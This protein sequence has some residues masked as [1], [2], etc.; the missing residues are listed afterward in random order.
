MNRNNAIVDRIALTGKSLGPS[1]IVNTKVPAVQTMGRLYRETVVYKIIEAIEDGRILLVYMP[2]ETRLPANMPYVKAQYHGK[3]VSV[4]D[5]SKFATIEQADGT[6][7]NVQIDPNKLYCLVVPAY[8]DLVLMD[9]TV[10]LPSE[11]IRTMSYLWA[12]MFNKVLTSKKI[13]V[14]NQEKHQAFMYFAMRFFMKYYLQSPDAVVENISL[15]YL[16][17]V[18]T[19][20]VT[21][22]NENLERKQIDLYKDW[23]TFAH[24]MFNNEITNIASFNG[25]GVNM[26]EKLYLQYFDTTFGK[27]GAYLAL[28]TAPYFLYTLFCTFNRGYILNDRAW[29]D[30]VLKEKKVMVNLMTSLYK[31]I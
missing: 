29:E 28:W 12:K 22:I 30:I 6:I 8:I 11:S 10:A 14:N 31:E 7:S 16:G 2:I 26:D 21:Q 3:V 15:A 24:T 23:T 27:D 18:M 13:F 5:I 25:R 4:V 20:Y 1:T 17:G 9:Q 19:P